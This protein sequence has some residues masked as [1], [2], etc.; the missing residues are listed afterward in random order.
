VEDY[1]IQRDFI[2]S[3]K[4]QRVQKLKGSAE[5]CLDFVYANYITQWKGSE[6]YGIHL[7]LDFAKL[8]P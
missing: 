8:K 2:L 4:V 3:P 6:T 1:E 5:I 7:K